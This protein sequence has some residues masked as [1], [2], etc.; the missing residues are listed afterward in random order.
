MVLHNSGVY[1]ISKGG[2]DQKLKKHESESPKI[3]FGIQ[4]SN[5]P[6]HSRIAY[7]F[8][9]L[10]SAHAEIRV[11]KWPFFCRCCFKII[12]IICLFIHFITYLGP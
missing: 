9:Q 7:L 8:S 1:S 11:L 6:I 3:S 2:R 10:N 4:N 12:I 5:D